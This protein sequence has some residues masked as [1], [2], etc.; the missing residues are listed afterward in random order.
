MAPVSG[1]C[2]M[3]FSNEWL[4]LFTKRAFTWRMWLSFCFAFWNVCHGY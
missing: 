4:N 3:D 2:V 1:A